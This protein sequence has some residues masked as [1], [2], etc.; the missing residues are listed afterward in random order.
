MKKEQERAEAAFAEA[1]KGNTVAV[2]SSGDAGVY[3]MA[4]LLWELK[5][6]IIR[7]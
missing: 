3:G 2:I 4:P 7:R 1:E 6:K 5:Q